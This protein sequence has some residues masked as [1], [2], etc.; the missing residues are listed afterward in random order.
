MASVGCQS[1]WCPRLAGEQQIPRTA[2][3][4]L[5]VRGK[6]NGARDFA[7]D[8]K[9]RRYGEIARVIS[10]I[11]KCHEMLKKGEADNRRDVKYMCRAQLAVSLRK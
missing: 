11:C 4:A 1:R 8:D 2:S 9:S 7:R 10:R 5:E 6:D 3:H